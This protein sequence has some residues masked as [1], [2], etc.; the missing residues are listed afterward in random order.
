LAEHLTV[1]PK[2]LPRALRIL[3]ELFFAFSQHPFGMD[4]PEGS[5][6]KL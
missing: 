1:S 4:W 3:D 6:K 5:D 2:V